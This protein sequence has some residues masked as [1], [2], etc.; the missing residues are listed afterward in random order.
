[1]TRLNIKSKLKENLALAAFGG[2]IGILNGTL[3]AG[4]GV[5]A[6]PLLK[7][8]GLSQKESHANA[9]AVILPI[10]L[11]SASIYLYKGNVT[12][13]EAAIYMPT[14]LLGVIIGT[15]LLKKISALWLNRI[16]GAIMVYAGVRLLV[17]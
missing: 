3:G 5:I 11:I 4:G 9:I 15:Y 17:R 8:I 12:L 14:G 7:K 2:L 16:F 13:R 6:V 10:T 1:M